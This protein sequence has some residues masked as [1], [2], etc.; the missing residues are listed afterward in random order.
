ML[1]AD[2]KSFV[3]CE[4]LS[5][6]TIRVEMTDRP[7]LARF[8]IP[9][10]ALGMHVGDGIIVR[11]NGL[12]CGFRNVRDVS[13]VRVRGVALTAKGGDRLSG[14]R[15]N[16]EFSS[17]FQAQANETLSRIIRNREL[18]CYALLNSSLS[19]RIEGK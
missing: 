2:L 14:E 19:P 5:F 18:E 16:E 13:P 17:F 15:L 3:R 12:R 8:A 11:E 9:A 1:A 6:L 10:L 4:L 7:G